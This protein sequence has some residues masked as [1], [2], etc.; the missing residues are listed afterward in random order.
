[1]PTRDT[2]PAG[3]PCWI[4][5]L[6]SDPERT[7]AF[8]SQLFGWTVVDPGP[9]YGGY[10]N[11]HKDGVPVAGS[12]GGNGQPGET[13]FWTVY[14][15]SADAAATVA[16]A[17]ANG[18]QVFLPAMD[19]MA[20]GRMAVLGDAGGSGVGVWQPGEHAGFGVLGEPGTPNWFELHTRAYGANV[21]FYRDV[22]GWDAHTMSDT[23]EF[24][25]T[26]L[27]EG[28]GQL[29]GI[30]DAT[31]FPEDAPE[32]W[33]IYFGVTGAGTDAALAK[34]EQLGGTI[35]LPAE[36]TPFGRIAQAADPTGALF[37]LIG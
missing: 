5:I 19:V 14:L 27:G 35:V 7:R 26:T 29:A 36:D 22:F 12:M 23:P 4:D 28:D 24:R 10:A 3:A 15:A 16:L 33:S 11:F 17:T 31:V 34:V 20:L 18:G 25:Y 8:Y 30:M 2:A 37:K 13:D 6:S 32:G 1:M 9:D 21:R